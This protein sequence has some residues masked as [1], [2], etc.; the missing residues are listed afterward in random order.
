MSA[1]ARSV[2]VAGA[3]LELV[4]IYA[5]FA[6]LWILVSDRAIE[7]IFDDPA[8]LVLAS[9]VKGWLFVAVTSALLYGLVR[10]LL[11]KL[12]AAD[13]RERS[14]QEDNLRVLRLIKTVAE[15]SDD[16]IFAKDLDGRYI[17]F[18]RAAS[19]F[20]GKPAQDVLGRDDGA[21]FPAE[22]A[23]ALRARTREV[24]EQNHN[25]VCEERLTTALGER[26]FLATKGPLH[27]TDGRVIGIFGTSR[28]ITARKGAEEELKR[29]NEEL[30][31]FNRASVGR[32][33][34]MIELKK[35]VNALS[36]ELGRE[37]PY[38]LRFL[39]QPPVAGVRAQT[40]D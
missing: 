31:R 4:C 34:D 15:S 36:R 40:D 37:P 39:D 3:A 1:P 21:I 38:S 12:S 16:A 23:A 2:S 14:L 18:N 28:D 26:V 35:E 11:A 7:L 10:R 17:L 29:R 8:R 30:E 5:F 19:V 25:V 24:I 9:M 27:D 13:A 6:T 20:V 32:E 22:Q 33:L